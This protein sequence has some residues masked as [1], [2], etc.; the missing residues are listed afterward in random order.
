MK[1]ILSQSSMFI[2]VILSVLTLTGCGQSGVLYLPEHGSKPDLNTPKSDVK[3]TQRSH[4]ADVEPM[5][6]KER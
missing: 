3:P 6:E 2:L 5:I 4:S 1:A